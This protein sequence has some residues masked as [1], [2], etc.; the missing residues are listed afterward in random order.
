MRLPILAG[1]LII[2]TSGAAMAQGIP[3]A[4]GIDYTS[5]S[6]PGNSV[7]TTTVTA[8]ARLSLRERFKIDVGVGNSNMDAY[9]SDFG[10][11]SFTIEPSIEITPTLEVG[12]YFGR[13]TT[14]TPANFEPFNRV[15]IKFNYGIDDFRIDGY[16]GELSGDSVTGGGSNTS[17]G[18]SFEYDISP[19]LQFYANHDRDNFDFRGMDVTGTFF[20]VRWVV[21]DGIS[22]AIPAELDFGVGRMDINGVDYDQIRLGVTFPLGNSNGNSGNGGVCDRDGFRT[23]SSVCEPDPFRSV[24]LRHTFSF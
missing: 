17:A 9:G 19:K 2:A 5:S 24:A 8:T 1:V 7:D 16:Y 23:S 6:A 3:G 22:S 18:L 10:A 14:T 15:G 11:T 13:T 12:A 21:F 20:G 4:V